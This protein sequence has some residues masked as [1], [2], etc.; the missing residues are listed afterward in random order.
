MKNLEALAFSCDEEFE[1]YYEKEQYYFY[2]KENRRQVT[3]WGLIA[4]LYRKERHDRAE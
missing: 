2:P 1:L 4:D 3:R